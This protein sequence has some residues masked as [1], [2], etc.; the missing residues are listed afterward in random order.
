MILAIKT[1]PSVTRR[2]RKQNLHFT[3]RL[4]HKC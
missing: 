1:F 4:N 2:C 3:N